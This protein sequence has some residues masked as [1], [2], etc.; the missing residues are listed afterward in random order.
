MRDLLKPILFPV[1]PDGWPYIAGTAAAA[2]L[3]GLL[4]TSAF[5]VGAIL[6][7]WCLCF[8]RNPDR[9][10]P[11]RSGLIV[12]PADGLVEEVAAVE[13]PPELDMGANPLVRI[14]IHMDVFDCHVNRIP[15]D[16]TVTRAE[17]IPGLF[18]NLAFDKASEDNERRLL[19][20]T[21]A[22]GRHVGCVQIAGFVARRI[23]SAVERGQTVRAGEYFGMIR[24]GSRLDVYLPDGAAP[25]VAAGQKMVAGE[26][27]LADLAS[28]ESARPGEM[29]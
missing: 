9:V 3:L 27:V 1:H 28:T 22:E 25:L 10:T 23:V 4:S 5:W 19:R 15:I 20:I 8:F 29:R 16:G 18:L 2:L 26:T 6:T 11:A 17:Y 24:F 21:T 14:A 12:S 7:G 13:P